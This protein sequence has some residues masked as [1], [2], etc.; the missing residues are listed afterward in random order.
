M[1]TKVRPSSA[2][3]R[4]SFVGTV[5]LTP[6]ESVIH[7]R[8]LH[9]RFAGDE[10]TSRVPN[11][12]QAVTREARAIPRV[13]SLLHENQPLPSGRGG[14]SAVFPGFP[15]DGACHAGGSAGTWLDFS[16]TRPGEVDYTQ[17]HPRYTAEPRLASGANNRLRRNSYPREPTARTGHSLRRFRNLGKLTGENCGWSVSGYPGALH[18]SRSLERVAT[19]GAIP[20]RNLGPAQNCYNRDLAEGRGA[21][22]PRG[23]G[24]A[25]PRQ[26]R[27]Q[28]AF[29]NVLDPA[30][31]RPV[32]PS[33]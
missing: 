16:S 6:S 4:T 31:F 11:P 18:S 5:R 19:T 3:T 28:S 32:E 14:L 12:V 1:P 2:P 17:S 30:R 24:R 15:A 21:V 33:R 20:F 8:K 22:S 13:H 25:N 23:G 29:F 10:D 26:P 9:N 27:R 7:R